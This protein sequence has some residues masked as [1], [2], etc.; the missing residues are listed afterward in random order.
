MK[1]TISLLIASVLVFG[2]AVS[3]YA[4]AAPAIAEKKEVLAQQS[5]LEKI[6]DRIGN[7]DEYENFYSDVY[8]G[9][10]ENIYAFDWST[11]GEDRKSLSVTATD[12]GIITNYNYMIDNIV[13]TVVE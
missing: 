13:V 2:A 10:N 1:K 11:E 9:G 7:T 6:K 5:V 8:G 3:S 12:D 4:A